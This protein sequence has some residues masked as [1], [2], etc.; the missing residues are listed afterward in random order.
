M[1][2]EAVVRSL[3]RKVVVRHPIGIPDDA[4]MKVFAPYL[5]KGLLHRIDLAL[6]CAADWNRRYPDPNL[7]PEVAWLEAGLFSGDNEQALPRAFHVERT[8]PEKDGS[9]RVYVQLTYGSRQSPWIWRV[10]PILRRENGHFVIEDVIYLKDENRKFDSRLSEYLTLGC[11]GGH[12][13]GYSD[14]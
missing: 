11:D 10:A 7:K 6:A 1:Q 8:Q 14:K 2:P 4:G 5:S 12:W 9:F 3:Y 13:V